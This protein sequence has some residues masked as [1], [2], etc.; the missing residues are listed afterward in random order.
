[1]EELSKMEEVLARFPGLGK[2]I[3][4]Q[5][6]NQNFCKCKVV[7]RSL[8]KCIEENEPFWTRVIKKYNADPVKFK[9]A[10]KLVLEKIPVQ[11]VEDLA[12]AVEQFLSFIEDVEKSFVMKRK[13]H[14]C[15][16]IDSFCT[17]RLIQ[18]HFPH[19]TAANTWFKLRS[20]G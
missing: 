1:M 3:F 12:F 19:H 18:Q 11:N 9:D 4:N 13:E 20:W 5:L 17:L 8:R 16:H 14:P 15:K 10:W 2:K 7:S 6:D